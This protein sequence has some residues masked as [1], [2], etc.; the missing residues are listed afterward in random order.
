MKFENEKNRS[1][2]KRKMET[3]SDI[4]S[5]SDMSYISDNQQYTLNLDELGKGL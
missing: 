5:V 3:F 4:E 1:L 2:N